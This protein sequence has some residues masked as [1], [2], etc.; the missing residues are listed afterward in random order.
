MRRFCPSIIVAAVTILVSTVLPAW[1]QGKPGP[2]PAPSP[3]SSA[4]S[5]VSSVTPAAGPVFAVESTSLDLGTVPEGKD[6]I[7]EFVIK[8]LGK[9][10]LRILKAKPG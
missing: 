4:A 6:V 8:N 5:P 3:P 2:V 1:S 9:A 7:G 10:D